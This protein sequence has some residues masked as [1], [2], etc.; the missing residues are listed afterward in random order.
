[1]I[2]DEKERAEEIEE[3]SPSENERR[4]D[5]VEMLRKDDDLFLLE[6][7]PQ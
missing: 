1:M 7:I 2:S 5:D 6:R 4:D 3:M